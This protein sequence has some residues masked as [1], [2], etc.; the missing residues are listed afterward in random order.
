MIILKTAIDAFIKVHSSFTTGAFA[1][2]LRSN[3]PEVGRSTVYHILKQL[4]ESGKIIRTSKG[5]YDVAGKK[6]YAYDLSD[7]A[8]EISSGIRKEFPLVD[9][10]K[11]IIPTIVLPFEQREEYLLLR[12]EIVVDGRTREGGL[13]ADLLKGDF[14]EGHRLVQLLACIDDLLASGCRCFF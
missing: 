10:L 14:S 1:D 8:K 5:H 6:N 2:M 4:C 11:C 3:S 7:A 12:G 9:F 13:L